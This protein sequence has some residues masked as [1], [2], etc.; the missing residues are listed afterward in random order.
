MSDTEKIKRAKLIVSSTM[1]TKQKPSLRLFHLLGL[2]GFLSLAMVTGLLW[3]E[4]RDRFP[5]VQPGK[6]IGTY[7]GLAE[8]SDAVSPFYIERRH[9]SDRFLFVVM[10][11]GWEPSLVSIYGG[12]EQK[13]W[14][15]SVVIE[16]PDATLQFSG[17]MSSPG[18]FVGRVHNL[19]S[20][21]Q[22]LWELRVANLQK[23]V[24]SESDVAERRAWVSRKYDLYQVEQQID[25]S[26]LRIPNQEKRITELTKFIT[27]GKNL[28]EQAAEKFRGV[29]AELKEA[30][31][32]LASKRSQAQGLE[33]KLK[34]SQRV[35][36]MGELVSLAR[37]SME[38]ENRWIDTMI[39]SSLKEDSIAKL[40]RESRRGESVL[41]IRNQI[42]DEREKILRLERYLA[43]D[44]GALDSEG[45]GGG[46]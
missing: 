5:V 20:G 32:R 43:G 45:R 1:P 17:S 24:E 22:G 44:T 8:S 38:R 42:L 26:E 7:S 4:L 46:L 35:T 14:V 33:A 39:N 36:Q 34:L 19:S 3:I 9:G 41:R 30:K 31:G 10:K 2:L 25:A 16:G 29:R 40:G 28:K 37:D 21:E 23:S 27:E 6:Y 15:P 12:D 18:I 11:D 13:T